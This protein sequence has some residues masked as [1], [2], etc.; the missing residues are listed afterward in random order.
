M[1]FQ[2]QSI[3]VS[4]TPLKQSKSAWI[5]CLAKIHL[6]NLYCKLCVIR[7][8]NRMFRLPDS[9]FCYCASIDLCA[10]T[11]GQKTTRDRFEFWLRANPAASPDTD[12]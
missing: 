12:F 9:K 4:I 10:S 1:I 5:M 11:L 7:V 8:F 3:F 6:H 2:L